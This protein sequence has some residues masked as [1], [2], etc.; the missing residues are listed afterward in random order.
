MRRYHKRRRKEKLGEPDG[1]GTH[2]RAM[3]P[4][5]GNLTL[6]CDYKEDGVNKI[7]A[8]AGAPEPD[9]RATGG[10]LYGDQTRGAVR[11]HPDPAEVNKVAIST[12]GCTV[13]PA[14]VTTLGGS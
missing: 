8:T 10:R 4:Q 7:K 12:S 13:R 1:T 5:T 6:A 3:P 9:D 11:V 14:T 2:Y